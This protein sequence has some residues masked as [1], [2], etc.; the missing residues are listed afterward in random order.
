MARLVGRR[1]VSCLTNARHYGSGQPPAPNDAK[2]NDF[3]PSRPK[4]RSTLITIGHSVL[5]PS[6]RARKM[7]RRKERWQD[8]RQNRRER[9]W[10][11]AVRPKGEAQGC[12]ESTHWSFWIEFAIWRGGRVVEC[13]GLENQQRFVAFRGFESHPLRQ[14]QPGPSGPVCFWERAPGFEP[15]STNRQESRFGRTSAARTPG[16]RGAGMHRVNPS[17]LE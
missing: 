17:V 13:T 10:T 11:N 8:G 6:H 14:K 16:G 2:L 15:C 4:S 9:F 3:R 1:S 7:R 5:N 12:A